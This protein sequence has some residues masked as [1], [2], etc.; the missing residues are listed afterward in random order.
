MSA[1]TSTLICGLSF[2]DFCFGTFDGSLGFSENLNKK[3][4]DNQ[5][6]VIF[7]FFEGSVWSDFVSTKSKSHTQRSNNCINKYN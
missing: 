7:Y 6:E 2:S 3:G 1:A 5:Y 4:M